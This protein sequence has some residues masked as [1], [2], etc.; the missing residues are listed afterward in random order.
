MIRAADLFCGAGGTSTG[1][2]E[3]AMDF[4]HKLE[5]TAI[6]HWDR[7]IATHTANH[8]TARH[9]CTSIDVVNPRDLF[10]EGSLDILWASPECTHHSTA[11]GGKPINDQSRATAWCVTRWAEALRPKVI[12]VENVK[13]FT[14]WGPIGTNGRP[15]KSK[16]GEVFTAWV[17]TL[18]A[19][20][21]RVEWKILCAADY[22][23]PTTRRRLFVC[24]VLGRRKVIWPE[25]TH[26]KVET[27]DMF[28]SRKPWV[29]AREIIDWTKVG[30]SIYTR[31]K[32][33]AE[34]TMER[35]MIGLQKFGLAPFIVPQHRGGKPVHPVT[36]PVSTVTTTSRGVGLAEPF[37]V[38]MRGNCDAK[39]VDQPIPTL[40]AGGGH[41]GI[42]QPF[43]V[44]TAHGK[45]SQNEDG[46][47]RSVGSPL[48]TIA[49]N[50]GDWALCEPFIISTDH[51]GG[52]GIGAKS[53]DDPLTTITTKQRH[54]ACKPFLVRYNG[55][56]KGK[57]D[58]SHRVHNPEEPLPNVDTSNRYGI[59][60]PY[61]IKFYGTATGQ[62]VSEPLGTVTT[63]ERFG[64]A[65]PIVEIDGEKYL[66]D[67]LFRML[68]PRELASAQGFPM[69][70]QFTGNV[71]EIVKQVGNA[72]PKNLA[73]ALAK[74]AMQQ[75]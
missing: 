61:L 60:Q 13:E 75:L 48:P 29:A 28:G 71:S 35:I 16:R 62:P 25:P 19:L 36:D 73:K 30:K 64:L 43:L 45:S 52:G 44:Q 41:V 2:M 7:A 17:R 47:S 50:R 20:G 40:T 1:L 9:L 63:K 65:Q 39:S 56:H 8:P 31:K 37:L 68:N 3:A 27:A 33:L 14:T 22:G 54:A 34:K 11:R 32:P 10:K 12:L 23:D 21:Y 26:H 59:A 66:I 4:G 55:D 5:L 24:A 57:A 18:E 74:S 67:I 49:G 69:D 46:R 53:I 38:H 70:Y 42:A 6:N 15:L 72:V 58:G 51:Q